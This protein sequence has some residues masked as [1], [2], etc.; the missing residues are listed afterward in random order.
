M[1]DCTDELLLYAAAHPDI[2]QLIDPLY[3]SFVHPLHA[4]FAVAVAAYPTPD[5]PFAA[6]VLANPAAADVFAFP[7]TNAGKADARGFVQHVQALC[8]GQRV[9]VFQATGLHLW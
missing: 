6:P 8:P 7:A 9:L 1:C 3:V 4:G 2:Q 5:S